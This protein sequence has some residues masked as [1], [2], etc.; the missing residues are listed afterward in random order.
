M[1]ILKNKLILIILIFPLLLVAENADSLR[2]RIVAKY[3]AIDTFQA[4]FIQQNI[5]KELDKSFT[6]KGKIYYDKNNLIMLYAEPDEQILLVT[7]DLMKFYSPQDA[8]LM[9]SHNDQIN[10]EPVKILTQYWDNSEITLT[11]EG[12]NV[13]ITLKYNSGKIEAIVNNCLIQKISIAD[14][15]QNTV[16][17][18]FHNQMI[19]EKLPENIFDIQ[20]SDDVNIIDTRR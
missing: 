19:N 3:D 4:D 13:V 11:N 5:W 8:Q 7:E 14:L 6:S 18:E 16:S 9:I 15:E 10:L 20:L 12:E 2:L 1:A 17:Y